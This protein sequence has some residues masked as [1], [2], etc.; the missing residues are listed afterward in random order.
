MKIIKDP[1]PGTLLVDDGL[2]ALRLGPPDTENVV[3]LTYAFITQGPEHQILPSVLLDDWGKEIG[4]LALYSWI[5]ENGQRFPR[6]ELFGVAPNGAA[7][8]YF[9]RDLE[10]LANY[11]LYAFAGENA[12]PDSAVPVRAV[13]IPD[14]TV[15]APQRAAPPDDVKFPLNRAR[16]EWWRANPRRADLDFLRQPPPG[17]ATEIRPPA[18]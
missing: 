18:T 11:P 9:L 10:L 14:D 6:A 13:L 16:V 12:A 1:T 17:K 8:Q 2:A 7:A 15:S 3:Y 4:K 5:E